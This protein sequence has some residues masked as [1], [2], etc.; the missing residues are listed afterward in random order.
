MY[1]SLGRKLERF[2]EKRVRRED[3]N[4]VNHH[5]DDREDDTPAICD[6][7]RSTSQGH[8]D[9]VEEVISR[10]QTISGLPGP[11]RS[12]DMLYQFLGRKLE[13]TLGKLADS[14]GFGPEAAERTIM[15]NSQ[16]VVRFP[17]DEYTGLWGGPP[18]AHGAQRYRT[19]M[20]SDKGRKDIIKRCKRLLNYARWVYE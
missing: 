16:A 4:H 5:N 7:Q 15:S 9:C 2:I 12:L 18:V 6:H 1:Q 14:A 11:G 3:N 19:I 10:N 20:F 8:C 13:R 17:S